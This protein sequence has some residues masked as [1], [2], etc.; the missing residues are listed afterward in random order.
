MH[1]FNFKIVIIKN[2]LLSYLFKFSGSFTLRTF[3]PLLR[4]HILWIIP[5]AL[6]SPLYIKYINYNAKILT[7]Y[8]RWL[9]MLIVTEKR[10]N[11]R[12]Y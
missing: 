7:D 10:D 3:I 9:K 2:L 12:M 5:I 11:L 4:S 6:M 1:I 8:V